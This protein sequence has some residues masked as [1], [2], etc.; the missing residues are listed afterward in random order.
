MDNWFIKRS[1]FLYLYSSLMIFMAL[2]FQPPWDYTYS[3][4][5]I[6]L[7]GIA[8]VY[9]F[10]FFVFLKLISMVVMHLP[11]RMVNGNGKNKF[12][13]L[14][15]IPAIF[16]FML[17]MSPEVILFVRTIKYI[18]KKGMGLQSDQVFYL[19]ALNI[20]LAVITIIF[21]VFKYR[22]RYL[23][24]LYKRTVKEREYSGAWM[25]ISDNNT[26]MNTWALLP[27]FN[28]ERITVICSGG[29]LNNLNTC[30][31]EMAPGF[32]KLVINISRNKKAT[33]IV[34]AIKLLY[35][36]PYI[37]GLIITHDAKYLDNYKSEMARIPLNCGC[38]IIEY[39]KPIHTT[40]EYTKILQSHNKYPALYYVDCSR[41][42]EN[43]DEYNRLKKVQKGPNI[44]RDMLFIMFRQKESLASMYILFDIIDL[45]QRLL[46]AFY[47]PQ[48]NSWFKNASRNIGNIFQMVTYLE[49]FGAPL[50]TTKFEL[51]SCD[52]ILK[53]GDTIQKYIKN[54]EFS[55]EFL[56][57]REIT[58][59]CGILRNVLRGHGS[60]LSSDIKS[61]IPLLLSLLLADYQILG[62]DEMN[63]D[64]SGNDV[65]MSYRGKEKVVSPFLINESNRL[66]VFN[67]FSKD[68][69]GNRVMEYVDYIN[70]TT[71]TPSFHNVNQ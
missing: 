51:A 64:Y 36:Y 14:L 4:D 17:C 30:P 32:N 60:V 49:R 58:Y 1:F 13:Y 22:I 39:K 5:Y 24:S 12:S 71:M 26:E 8:I 35:D 7:G 44:I 57:Y 61:V 10:L 33:E 19:T 45:M 53:Y 52:I 43:D 46:L 54:Y 2:S 65:V 48:E 41:I 21:F 40:G 20:V 6:K 68:N 25:S 66:L 67:N 38:E 55:S 27:D 29:I 47:A 50:E 37:D 11:K 16:D 56:S 62:L 28:K 42:F 34:N 9:F 18:S 15:T 63:I 23:S 3:F 31:N 70:G 59:M 69:N